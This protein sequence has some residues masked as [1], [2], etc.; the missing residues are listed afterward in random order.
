MLFRSGAMLESF[1]LRPEV[2]TDDDVMDILKQA[3][4]QSGMK[5]IVAESV[6]LRVAGESLTE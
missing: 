6:K 2:L 4:S 1:L 5:E 3:F